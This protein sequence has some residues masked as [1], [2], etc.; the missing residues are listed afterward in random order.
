MPKEGNQTAALGVGMD[1]ETMRA[2]FI[3]F[4]AVGIVALGYALI[5]YKKRAL[6][7]ILLYFVG[8]MAAVTLVFFLFYFS[9]DVKKGVDRFITTASGGSG[10]EEV[11]GV[12]RTN[13]I[14]M[15]VV[16]IVMITALI[17]Y[18][19]SM[20]LAA[21]KLLGD[22]E[23]HRKAHARRAVDDAISSIIRGDDPRSVVIRCYNDM[24]LIVLG[25]GVKGFRPL[26]PGEFKVKIKEELGVIGSSVDQLTS[27]FEEARYSQHQIGSEHRDRALEALRAFGR[28]LGGGADA[29]V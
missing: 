9:E 3:V 29:K 12:A 6:K 24:C 28:E 10:T 7:A 13:M 20:V 19:V 17:A 5:T 15:T 4:Y 21:R 14:M 11:A 2:M 8:G 27:L 1:F 18:I 23:D 25:K 26:T 16:A 22:E